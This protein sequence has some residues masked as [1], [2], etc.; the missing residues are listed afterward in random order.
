MWAR[1]HGSQLTHLALSSKQSALDPV[2]PPACRT[3]RCCCSASSGSSGSAPGK[4]VTGAT[5]RRWGTGETVGTPDQGWGGW[6]F[7]AGQEGSLWSLV[8]EARYGGEELPCS[9][10]FRA[11]VCILREAVGLGRQFGL[12]LLSPPLQRSPLLSLC[13]SFKGILFLFFF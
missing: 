4:Q 3:P 5:E 13:A 7:R 10:S 1:N 9:R 2:L 8:V 12:C 6:L 11:Q